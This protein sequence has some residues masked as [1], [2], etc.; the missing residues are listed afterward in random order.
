MSSDPQQVQRAVRQE[1]TDEAF[2]IAEPIHDPCI[3]PRVIPL[4]NRRSHRPRHHRAVVHA[5]MGIGE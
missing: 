3:G 4:I 2:A 1:R 5:A